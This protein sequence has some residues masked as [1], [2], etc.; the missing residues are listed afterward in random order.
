MNQAGGFLG[1]RTGLADTNRSVS[2]GAGAELGQQEQI[3]FSLAGAGSCE[4]DMLLFRLSGAT[5]LIRHTPSEKKGEP[6]NSPTQDLGP[7]GSCSRTWASLSEDSSAVLC[8]PRLPSDRVDEMWQQG[9][10]SQFG[11]GTVCHLRFQSCCVRSISQ[12]ALPLLPKKTS[13][14]CK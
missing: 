13:H 3:S 12:L 10:T 4:G 2:R 9:V 7:T 6:E 8:L 11:E 5:C 14:L 1:V